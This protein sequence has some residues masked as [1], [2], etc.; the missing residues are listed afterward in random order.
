VIRPGTQVVMKSA[1]PSRGIATK[2]GTVFMAGIAERGRTDKATL[3]HNMDEYVKY[4]GNRVNYGLLYDSCDGAFSSGAVDIYVGRVVGTGASVDTHTFNDAGA[5]PSLAVDTLGQFASGWTA[6]VVAGA[7]AGTAHVVVVNAAGTV[8]TQ[9]PDYAAPVDFA[10]WSGFDSFIRIRAL[11]ANVPA[12]TAAVALAGG[13]DQR[14]AI[15]DTVKTNALPTLFPKG[16][17][18]GQVEYPGATTT[19]MHIA[20]ANFAATSGR[21]SLLDFPDSPTASVEQTEADAVRAGTVNLDE[22]YVLAL[23][24]WHKVPGLTPNTTRSLPPSA[25]TAGLIAAS[26]GRFNNPNIPA[27]GGNG[28]AD[29]VL[30]LTQAEWDDTTR[31]ALNDKGVAVYR[32]LDDSWRLYGYRTLADSADPASWAWESF[33]AARLRMAIVADLEALGEQ[34][35]F[36]Q[37]D[38]RGQKIAE[39]AGAC[40]GVLQQYWARGALYGE[41]AQDAYIVDT[42]P[43]VNT[44]ATIQNNELHAK[45]GIRTSPFNEFSYFEVTKVP[46]TEVL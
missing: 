43:T 23:A 35:L 10:N 31:S 46:V 13:N 38:G 41:S 14:G 17:G 42:G 29:F 21:V 12:A 36:A 19:A 33:A 20:L 37:L 3:I 4:Y 28:I 34:F 5:A 39:F 24:T 32:S 9:T 18:I 40:S 45:I 30:G 7:V 16:L 2:S 6:Q 25:V 8:V 27:A 1:P 26:D 22:T 44:P 15:D 11:G